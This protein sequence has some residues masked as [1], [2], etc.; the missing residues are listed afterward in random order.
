MANTTARHF[1]AKQTPSQNRSTPEYKY[2][3][4]N[5]KLQYNQGASTSQIEE[6]TMISKHDIVIRKHVIVIYL[7]LAMCHADNQLRR[8]EN[9]DVEDDPYGLRNVEG[10][11]GIPK[12][13]LRP[14]MFP[15]PG[16][17]SD[18]TE[19]FEMVLGE[20]QGIVGG[21]QRRVALDWMVFPAEDKDKACGGS[22][23]NPTTVVT[24]A[25]FK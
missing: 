21:S 8:T 22:L 9:N 23:V 14:G 10:P 20:D 1:V 5:R 19:H 12:E 7:L 25:H 6:G 2:G 18:I 17:P 3:T 24:A 15:P 4:L 13:A 16:T 11:V